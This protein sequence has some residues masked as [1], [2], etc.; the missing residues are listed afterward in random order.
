MVDD[1]NKI[2]ANGFI[3]K[4]N[5]KFEKIPRSNQSAHVPLLNLDLNQILCLEY[6]RQVRNVMIGLLHLK[7]NASSARVPF[8]SRI[9]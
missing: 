8:F 1:A 4:V 2:L 9:K 6:K 3:D 7:I 5:S